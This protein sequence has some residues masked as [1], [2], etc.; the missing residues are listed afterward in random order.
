MTN[1]MTRGNP[2][3]LI[4]AFH[5]PRRLLGIFSSSFTIWVDFCG[6]GRLYW[7][8][9]LAGSIG[10]TTS[11]IFLVTGWLQGITAAFLLW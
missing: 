9:A 7:C 11:L 8:G 5:D 4:L 6:G 2:V 10:S 3:R 1:D